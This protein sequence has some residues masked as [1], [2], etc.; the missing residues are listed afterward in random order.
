MPLLAQAQASSVLSVPEHFWTWTAKDGDGAVAPLVTAFAG[1]GPA[2]DA[3]RVDEGPE[4]YLERVAAL[5]PDLELDGAAAVLSTWPDG[6]YSAR[7]PDRPA[8]LDDRLE[9]TV[10]RI[11]FAGEHTERHW[12]STMEGALRS[13]ERAARQL[14]ASA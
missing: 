7:Q 4:R 6:A 1:S 8:D 5:R 10:G 13:G 14:L 2:V 12:Y 3:L 9:G 11:A